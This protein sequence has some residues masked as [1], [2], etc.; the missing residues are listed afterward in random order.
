MTTDYIAL[1]IE[2]LEAKIAVLTDLR[3]KLVT[4]RREWPHTAA[5]MVPAA[6]HPLRQ[7][8]P[9]T[10]TA[11]PHGQLTAEQHVLAILEGKSDGLRMAEIVAATRRPKAGIAR[12]LGILA[13]ARKV[14]STGLSRATRW[15][16]GP[17]TATDRKAALE[18]EVPAKTAAEAR[19]RAVER[20]IVNSG[21]AGASVEELL[22]VLPALEG[23]D[24][25]ITPSTHLGH[26]LRRLTVLKKVTR[27]GETDRYVM[28]A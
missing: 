12:A 27:L 8:R 26:A 18:P 20:R 1:A 9:R 14:H 16:L 19:D 24:A 3:D 7:G 15:H 10:T 11:D 21:A 28:I 23:D 25:R 17:A 13:Q 2:D 6:S 4:F 5:S 22:K